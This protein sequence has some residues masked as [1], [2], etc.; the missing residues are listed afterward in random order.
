M[1]NPTV[2]LSEA[3][4]FRHGGT[5]SK[6]NPQFWGGDIPW[7]SPKDMKASLITSTQ[8][9]ITAEGVDGSA[10][11][12]VP[13]GSILVVARSGILAHTVPVARAGRRLAF[14]QDIKAIQV[15]DNRVTGDYVYWFLRGKEAE[16]LARGV[17]K[18]ATVHSLQSGF[19]EKL[20][21]P[22]ASA[23]EQHRIVDLLSRAE[24]IVRMR[25]EAEQK[26]KEIIPATF[27]DM[28][29][30]PATNPKGWG[31]RLLGEIL[32]SI[33][34]GRSPTCL[35]R[36]RQV[37]EWGVL[38]L[39]AVTWGRYDEADHK[40]LPLSVAPH[41]ESEVRAGN[42]LLSRKN[43]YE[44][45]GASAY[46]WETAWR[47]LLPDLIFRL[48]IGSTGEVDPIYLWRLLSTP[49][50]RKQLRALASG[51]AASMPNIS[52]E[53]LRG[54]AVELPPIRRQLEFSRHVRDA[55]TLE[56]QQSRAA[57]LATQAFQSLLAGVFGET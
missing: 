18:G 14:N 9:S 36:P 40:T 43:T 31:R 22:I 42:V 21:I 3:C 17:K 10:A 12:V 55:H 7:V 4:T 47:I 54:L 28:F 1:T 52:K 57:S 13:E 29:G 49:S 16:I 5:P 11:S 6:S 2:P 25:R 41:G 23:S 46:V 35:D 33:D 50:K 20:A 44:L 37:G 19:L 8:D 32:V 56:G 53:R 26:A 27:L 34:S 15:T 39:G 38:K 45:V 24:S 51:A 48:N 30:D